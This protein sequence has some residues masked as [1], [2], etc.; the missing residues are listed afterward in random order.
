MLRYANGETQRVDPNKPDQVPTNQSAVPKVMTE[1]YVGFS[2]VVG[3]ANPPPGRVIN[4]HSFPWRYT[5]TGSGNGASQYCRADKVEVEVDFVA[6]GAVNG[7]ISWGIIM[8]DDPSGARYYSTNAFHSF[9]EVTD[10][11]GMEYT[12]HGVKT[13]FGPY[14]HS[15]LSHTGTL[16]A[17]FEGITDIQ[18]GNEV[19]F[20]IC[21]VSIDAPHTLTSFNMTTRIRPITRLL[22]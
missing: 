13:I 6:Y 20:N 1:S 18:D 19:W 9:D 14:S 16:K 22:D 10:A 2:A 3:S 5:G 21:A 17:V 8:H 15:V 7:G 4:T 12:T 11:N